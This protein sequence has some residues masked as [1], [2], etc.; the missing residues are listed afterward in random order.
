MHYLKFYI[1]VKQAPCAAAIN[2]V[3]DLLCGKVFFP[4]GNNHQLCIKMQLRRFF[5]KKNK[6]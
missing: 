6:E 5:I 1:S 4:A 2:C 3:E